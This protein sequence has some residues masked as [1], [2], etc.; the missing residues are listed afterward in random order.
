M[1]RIRWILFYGKRQ[2][3]AG[4]RSIAI[5]EESKRKEEVEDEKQDV[6]DDEQEKR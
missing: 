5:F 2:T 4:R 3:V 1:W 6:E